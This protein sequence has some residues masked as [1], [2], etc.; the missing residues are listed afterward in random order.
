MQGFGLCKTIFLCF[1]FA[2]AS[3]AHMTLST[4]RSIPIKLCYY[5]LYSASS[6]SP[7]GVERTGEGRNIKADLGGIDSDSHCFIDTIKITNNV[8]SMNK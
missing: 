1:A 4:Y 6:T 7:N 5:S 8:F 2:A 3:A